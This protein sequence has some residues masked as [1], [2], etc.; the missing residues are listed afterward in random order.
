MH[1]G[2]SVCIDTQAT[3]YAASCNYRSNVIVV[4]TQQNTA[5]KCW[6]VE[7]AARAEQD[8][9]AIEA[10]AKARVLS[11]IMLTLGHF[12]GEQAIR[13]SA[14]GPFR[15]LS[16]TSFFTCI[17]ML[18]LKCFQIS[19]A[20]KCLA[21]R[22]LWS[23]CLMDDFVGSLGQPRRGACRRHRVCPLQRSGESMLALSRGELPPETSTSGSGLETSSRI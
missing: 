2:I 1:C 8:V 7:A 14:N 17:S 10:S 15:G 5:T 19:W 22:T 11:C 12:N 21:S 16:T 23:I 4:P 6:C 9:V 20:R 13:L 18:R 3:P